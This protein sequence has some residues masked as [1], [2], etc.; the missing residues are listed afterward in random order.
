LSKGQDAAP[1]HFNRPTPLMINAFGRGVHRV[2]LFL[3]RCG[4][5]DF[6]LHVGDQ[7]AS[8]A[9]PSFHM[10]LVQCDASARAFL[11]KFRFPLALLLE[12]F[13]RSAWLAG[14]GA[15]FERTCEGVV[16]LSAASRE[17]ISASIRL[18]FAAFRSSCRRT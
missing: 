7:L 2:S 6:I 13:S 12:P 18:V 4:Q 10:S 17:R 1:A 9:L 16:K 3:L 14:V 8:G 15:F 5:R 11:F